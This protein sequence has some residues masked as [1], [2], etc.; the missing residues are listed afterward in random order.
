M[1]LN[2]VND[3]AVVLPH[4]AEAVRTTLAGVTFGDHRRLD[5]HGRLAR[6][7]EPLELVDLGARCITDVDDDVGWPLIGNQAA[8]ARLRL[9]AEVKPSA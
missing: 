1:R 7:P 8:P 3:E 4:Q 2:H 9:R 6:Q 5:V